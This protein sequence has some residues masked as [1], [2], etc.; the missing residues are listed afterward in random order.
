MYELVI[1]KAFGK[2]CVA[3]GIMHEQDLYDLPG[4]DA[5]IFCCGK[6]FVFIIKADGTNVL[7][8]QLAKTREEAEAWYWKEV[9]PRIAGE[10]E[11]KRVE[12]K[13]W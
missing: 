13:D 6:D 8:N 10:E 3:V 9:Y 5:E 7:K 2:K 12:N 1:E 4:R 11:A